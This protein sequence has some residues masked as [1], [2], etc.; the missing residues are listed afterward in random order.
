[1]LLIG[2]DFS[3]QPGP[4]KPIVM[5]LGRARAGVVTLDAL[6]AIPTLDAFATTLRAGRTW[7]GGF[8]LPFGLPRELVQTLGCPRNGSIACAPTRH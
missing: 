3:S 5:A 7:V 4:R 1:M 8:D 2:C 6:Q